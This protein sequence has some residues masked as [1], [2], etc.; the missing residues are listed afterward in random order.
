MRQYLVIGREDKKQEWAELCEKRLT[1]LQA[2][3][4]PEKSA[5]ID[6]EDVAHQIR[7]DLAKKLDITLR[8]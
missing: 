8:W 7:V 6:W 3:T 1:Q 5:T 4:P 2:L